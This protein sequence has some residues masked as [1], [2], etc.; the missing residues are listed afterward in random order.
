MQCVAGGNGQK[1]RSIEYSDS[2]LPFSSSFQFLSQ[3]C[4]DL[5]SFFPDPISFIA[6]MIYT[7]QTWVYWHTHFPDPIKYDKM[8]MKRNNW[9]I[10]AGNIT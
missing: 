4:P 7:L 10:E 9:D 5:S 8:G 2:R 1:P 6:F 3:M